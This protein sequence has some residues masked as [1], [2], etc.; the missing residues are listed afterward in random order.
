MILS[1]P[2]L[3][4]CFLI[5][6]Y[7][8]LLHS[9][10]LL[11]KE[12]FFLVFFF[13]K[14]IKHFHLPLYSILMAFMVFLFLLRNSICISISWMTSPSITEFKGLRQSH[15]LGNCRR[16]TCLLNSELPETPPPLLRPLSLAPGK[17]A[18]AEL[19]FSMFH[20]PMFH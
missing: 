7:L 14:F 5:K 12:L 8:T 13:F 11:L 6:F 19:P 18:S 15:K 17:L 2:L 4:S 1:K 9:L 10:S 16:W 20:I 3:H